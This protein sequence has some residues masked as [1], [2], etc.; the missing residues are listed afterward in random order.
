MKKETIKLTLFIISIIIIIFLIFYFKP[1][2][3]IN[4]KTA[5]CIA[6]K[7]KLYVLKTCGHCA[8]QKEILK[9]YLHLFNIIECSQEE[10]F[11]ECSAKQISNVPAWFINGEKYS[12][13]K[14]VSL[15]ELKQATNC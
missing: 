6:G 4:E 13:G 15:I 8:A 2:G 7:T 1:K 10:N 11:P 12:S 3:E 14:A 5:E 9:D